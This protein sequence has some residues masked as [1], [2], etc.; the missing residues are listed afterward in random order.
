M[1]G[2]ALC[3]IAIDVGHSHAQPGA[4]SARGKPEFHFNLALARQLHA[5]LSEGGVDSFLI[6]ENGD[7]TDLLART[8]KASGAALLISVHHDAVQPRYLQSWTWQ[9]QTHGYCDRYD[10]FSLFVSRLNPF[11]DASLRCAAA[12]GAALRQ[13]GFHATSHHAEPIP[14]ENR[15][16]ADAEN[17]VHFYDELVVL[18]TAT[19]PAVLLEAGVIVNP[20]EELALADPAVQRRIAD[21][22]CRGLLAGVVP[23]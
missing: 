4:I 22:V 19:Q 10:G 15:P 21:A 6:G 1:I 17:G 11:F 12:I 7:I 16:F 9:G 5:T 8:A 13:A 14:G 3:S 20:A 2:F 23:K 18:R